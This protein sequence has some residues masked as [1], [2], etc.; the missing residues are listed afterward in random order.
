MSSLPSL[1]TGSLSD[2]E[3]DLGPEWRQAADVILGSGS[4]VAICHV[5][6]DGDTLGAGLGLTHVLRAMGK[7]VQPVCVSPIEEPLRFLPGADE[8][9]R[10]IPGGSWEVVVALDCSD[11][12]RFDPLTTRHAAL[13][14]TRPVINIDHHITNTRFGTINLV[15][16]GAAAT[17]EEVWRL[18]RLA[19]WPLPP[20][21]ATCLLTGLM[22][23]TG[24]FQYSNTSAGVLLAAAD[25][26]A[27]GA[28]PA[29]I[30][31]QVFR[32]KS[33]A[34][35]KLWGAVLSS[36]QRSPSGRVLWTC[37][38][39]EMLRAF[40][41]T[42]TTAEGISNWLGVVDGIDLSLVFKETPEGHT[43]LSIRTSEQ[44]DGTLLAQRLGGGGHARA[45]GCTL[46]KACP[47]A[48]AETLALVREIY[49]ID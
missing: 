2:A 3:S 39:Q 14:S 31:H 20:Q 13:F 10:D 32:R 26:A 34:T 25:L 33:F 4:V 48:I 17:A 7:R 18:V 23:D 11:V 49:G 42:M 29:A 43:Q 30:A 47:E 41:S 36:L 1:A 46:R 22:T 12:G 37:V 9:L 27:A 6:P 21:A 24:S 19:G 8:V 35:V 44:V 38:T 5:N 16:P 40:D 28:D 15:D 45:A